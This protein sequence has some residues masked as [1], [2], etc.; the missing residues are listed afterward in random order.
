MNWQ[1]E[2]E[3]NLERVM[4][5]WSYTPNFSAFQL[6]NRHTLYTFK[7]L[8]V[9]LLNCPFQ[10]FSESWKQLRLRIMKTTEKA[11]MAAHNRNPG[12]WEMEEGRLQI[13]SPGC[14]VTPP[15][16]EKGESSWQCKRHMPVQPQ[17]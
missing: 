15:T 4:D 1:K 13:Q 5:D 6:C 2:I 11:G 17:G 14:A 9:E 16:S 10:T 8:G 12:M 7:M 3:D